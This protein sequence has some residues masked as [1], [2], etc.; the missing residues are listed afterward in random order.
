[1]DE[2][3]TRRIGEEVRNKTLFKETHI[4]R[5]KHFLLTKIKKHD[6][7]SN[8]KGIPENFIEMLVDQISNDFV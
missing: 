6:I 3:V 5:N 4:R 7:F 8:H 1:M 2:V